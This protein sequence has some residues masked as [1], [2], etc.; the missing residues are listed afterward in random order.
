MPAVSTRKHIR[1]ELSDAAAALGWVRVS[2]GE[3]NL[4]FSG[5]EENQTEALV[6]MDQGEFYQLVEGDRTFPTFSITIFQDAKLNDTQSLTVLDMILKRG[7]ST[8]GAGA[9]PA[10]NGTTTDPGG[11]V[12]CTQARFQIIN[13]GNFSQI[14]FP[15][16]RVKIDSFTSAAN[17]NTIQISGTCY[18]SATSPVI[19]G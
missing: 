8:G 19:Y 6:V 1:F 4:T 5:L 10:A 13:G 12:W 16:C 15:N 7:A 3:G 18:P 9:S 2:P 14:I 11:V 17:G